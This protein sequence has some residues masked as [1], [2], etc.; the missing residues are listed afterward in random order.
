MLW[1]GFSMWLKIYKAASAFHPGCPG[2]GRSRNSSRRR[3]LTLSICLLI[4][5]LCDSN[6]IS[7]F[8]LLFCSLVRADGVEGSLVGGLVAHEERQ[9]LGG[10]VGFSEGFTL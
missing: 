3:P 9:V 7:S 10:A 1:T 5:C 2:V 8:F 4:K 6:P